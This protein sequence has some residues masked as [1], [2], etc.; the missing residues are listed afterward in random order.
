MALDP[1]DG[2]DNA[3]CPRCGGSF[4]CGRQ[5]ARCDCAQVHL[6][7]ATR[8]ALQRQFEGCLCVA[9]LRAMQAEGAGVQGNASR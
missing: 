9:C 8:A 6:D 3:R 4:H 7:D 2:D 1:R 5:D